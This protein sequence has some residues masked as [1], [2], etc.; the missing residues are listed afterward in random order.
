M[1]IYKTLRQPDEDDSSGMYCASRQASLVF[2]WT[3][4]GGSR[5]RGSGR[6]KQTW[7]DTFAED[8]Q[9]MSVSGAHDEAVQEM[10]A[11]GSG[12]HDEAR[13]V[14]SDRARWRQLVAQCSRSNT[15]T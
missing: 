5:R 6:P 2:D 1:M 14:A 7:R 12:I 15:R 9:E 3:P 8:M 4:E 10:D 13:S 11:S